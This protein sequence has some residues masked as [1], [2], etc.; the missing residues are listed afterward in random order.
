MTNYERIKNMSIE[1]LAAML[2]FSKCQNFC[3]YANTDECVERNGPLRNCRIGT[4]KW[5]ES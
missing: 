3:I 5:L 4:I 1:E 2:Y